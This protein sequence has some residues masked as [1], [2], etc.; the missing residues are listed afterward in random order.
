MAPTEGCS[1]IAV[2]G[3]GCLVWSART[4]PLGQ[5]ELCSVATADGLFPLSVRG[6]S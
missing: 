1:A 2:K 4:A 5:W 3:Y 6:F